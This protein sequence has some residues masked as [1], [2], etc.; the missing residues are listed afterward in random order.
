MRS[1]ALRRG[2]VA[3]AA[4]FILLGLAGCGD[5]S[6]DGTAGGG[7]SDAGSDTGTVDVTVQE[8]AVVPGVASTAAGDLTFNVTNEGEET[9]EFV[10]FKTDLAP[11]DLPT[12]DDGSVDEGGA[13]VE[14]INE[15]ENIEPGTT[16]DLT[17]TL[18][19]G[20][21]V[22]LCNILEGTESHY[23]NGM[24]TGFEVK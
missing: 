4:A 20:N 5:S 2:G 14:H 17:V 24:R 15:I 13:G 9:H 19:A 1:P 8:W 10:I 16:Q 18:D 21:Y 11:T 6:D 3:L 12:A 7:G 23:Q 22:F